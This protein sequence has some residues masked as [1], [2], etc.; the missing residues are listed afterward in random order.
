LI[1]H[2]EKHGPLS[3]IDHPMEEAV[4]DEATCPTCHGSGHTPGQKDVVCPT[5]HGD[6]E[7]PKLKA[8]DDMRKFHQ[9]FGPAKWAVTKQMNALL[10]GE[11][12]VSEE[13]MLEA[14]IHSLHKITKTK[15]PAMVKFKSGASAMVHHETAARIMKLH[16]MMKKANKR[17]IEGLVNS[18]PDGLKKV[19]EFATVHM[20]G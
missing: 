10:T 7:T 18:S 12:V 11:E 16:S 13:P 1:A 3:G 4:L 17:K 14:T 9:S 15:A 20:K 19:I 6:P 8:W 2:Q 5:C